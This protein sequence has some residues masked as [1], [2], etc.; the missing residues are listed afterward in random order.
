[1]HAPQNMYLSS[2]SHTHTHIHTP[3]RTCTQA[4]NATHNGTVLF[5][6]GIFLFIVLFKSLPL[7]IASTTFAIFYTFAGNTILRTASTRFLQRIVTQKQ[8]FLSTAHN[9]HNH[10]RP[11]TF[12]CIS[13]NNE[14]HTSARLR[15][16]I[17]LLIFR[18]DNIKKV[19]TI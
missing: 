17:A 9:Q 5:H 4:D 3:T 10:A 18:A 12:W 19:S 16:F 13:R 11:W 14:W 2:H 1:M 6:V 7:E 15:I 8:V